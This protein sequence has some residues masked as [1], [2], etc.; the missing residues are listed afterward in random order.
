MSTKQIK[1]N[2]E[3]L[4]RDYEYELDKK[5]L[6]IFNIYIKPFCRKHKLHFLSGNGTFGFFL[7]EKSDQELQK[8]CY[9]KDSIDFD[10]GFI[11]DYI[12]EILDIET[13]HRLTLGDW[14]PCYQPKY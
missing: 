9:Y 10:E 14:M 2:I 13:M 1:I 7:T 12:T 3:S 4:Q 6:E 5:A 8:F 11:P